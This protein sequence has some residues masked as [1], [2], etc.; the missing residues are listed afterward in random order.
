LYDV[1]V[2]EG[3]LITSNSTCD[4]RKANSFLELEVD[5][6]DMVRVAIGQKAIVTLD[7]GG[8]FEAIVDKIFQLWMLVLAPLK[9]KHIF[10]KCL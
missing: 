7:K 5:E 3:T 4:N 10:Y 2:D 6:N 1:L 9:L 8:G